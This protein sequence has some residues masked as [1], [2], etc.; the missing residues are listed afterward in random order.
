M[1]GFLAVCLLMRDISFT[2]DRCQTKQEVRGNPPTCHRQQLNIIFY[3]NEEG[4]DP[5]TGFFALSPCVLGEQQVRG[6]SV[7]IKSRQGV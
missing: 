6:Y 7:S 5:V 3:L 1:A 2:S 4:L